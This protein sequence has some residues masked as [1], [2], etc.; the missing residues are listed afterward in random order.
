MLELNS[1]LEEL[2]LQ[3]NQ[4]KSQGGTNI[5]NGLK[6]APKLR[7]L[8]FSWNSLGLNGS[9][10]AKNFA[11]YIAENTTLIHLDLSNNY[12]NKDDAKIIAE[13]LKLNHT[14]YGFH[15]YGNMGYV[16]HK[17]FLI[18]LDNLDS[19][20]GRIS[21]P[22]INSTFLSYVIKIFL[23]IN[24]HSDSL[25]HHI[26]N[27]GEYRDV[28][29]ICEGWRPMEMLWTPEES[30]QGD[31]DPIYVHLSFEGYKGVFLNSKNEFKNV[32]M[33][34]PT[35]FEYF[36]TVDDLPTYALNQKNCKSQSSSLNVISY[37][38][39]NIKG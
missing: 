3:W 39:Q 20:S 32:R 11:A 19:L 2:Y 21:Q 34:P 35:K 38:Y 33:V 36:F 16:D 23:G 37:L 7:V 5:V 18:V 10:F 25:K 15:F 24:F 30:G 8:D 31:R 17:G 27:W 13:D 29:W 4:I 14:L 1:S 6:L 26:G 28:C 22:P 9:Q 12:I